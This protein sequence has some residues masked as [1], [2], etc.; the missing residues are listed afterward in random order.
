MVCMAIASGPATATDEV[1]DE[2]PGLDANARDLFS[3]GCPSVLSL[4]QLVEEHTCNL[5][6]NDDGAVLMDHPGRRHECVVRNYVLF[7]GQG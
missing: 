2:F 3:K 5:V 1:D 6:W 4:G 7:F